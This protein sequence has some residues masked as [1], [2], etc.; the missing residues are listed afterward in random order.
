MKR[1]YVRVTD[2]QYTALKER[3]KAQGSPV[4]ELIRQTVAVVAA[5]WPLLKRAYPTATGTNTDL[6]DRDGNLYVPR[7]G[8]R[9]AMGLALVAAVAYWIF[10]FVSEVEDR[11]QH[12]LQPSGFPHSLW[13]LIWWIA[14]PLLPFAVSLVLLSRR[15]EEAIAAGA[16]VGA[17]L[18]LCSLLYS[19]LALF[20]FML[21]FGPVPYERPMEV[22]NLIFVACSVWITVSAFRIAHEAGWGVFFFSLAATLVGIT[23]AYHSLA[24]H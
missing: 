11:R 23:L 7:H 19:I 13:L 18:F 12:P 9:I 21:V 20:G 4:S 8:I 6:W 15:S 16:G 3:A 2:E 5:D 17:A 24:G 22:S 14:L 1:L 10:S